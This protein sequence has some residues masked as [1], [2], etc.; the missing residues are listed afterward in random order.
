V[1]L[2]PTRSQPGPGP[3]SRRLARELSGGPRSNRCTAA[4]P[5]VRNLDVS[6]GTSTA[7]VLETTRRRM[8]R[9]QRRSALVVEAY[10]VSLRPDSA[11][12]RVPGPDSRKLARKFSGGPRS[13]RCKAARP[14]SGTWTFHLEHRLRRF[15]ND[16]EKDA[17][18]ATAQR[19]RRGGLWHE[20]STGFRAQ[21]GSWTRQWKTG[22]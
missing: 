6:P 7:A 18:G 9:E 13:N 14:Q 2:R 17:Q 15:S 4:R 12:S 1:S 5:S 16:A 8:H 11:R 20:P 22:V 3:D 21:P 19:S 10:G